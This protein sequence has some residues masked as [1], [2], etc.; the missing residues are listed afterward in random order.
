ME[1][2][3]WVLEIWFQVRPS[4]SQRGINKQT[5]ALAAV[6]EFNSIFTSVVKSAVVTTQNGKMDDL[7]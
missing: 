7:K 3:E 6:S 5:V 4:A 2:T 1:A